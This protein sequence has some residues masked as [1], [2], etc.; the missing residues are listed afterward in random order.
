MRA[1]DPVYL[2]DEIIWGTE[3]RKAA[4]A[5]TE[6]GLPALCCVEPL[7]M[8]E[9]GSRYNPHDMGTNSAGVIMGE[10]EKYV[11]TQSDFEMG[12]RRD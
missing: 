8:K 7:L 1:S 9:P 12:A 5:A 4:L 10:L 3:G 6:K 2:M 11:R